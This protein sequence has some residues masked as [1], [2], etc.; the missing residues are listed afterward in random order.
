MS[1]RSRCSTPRTLS[2][3]IDNEWHYLRQS[4]QFSHLPFL[5]RY[6]LFSFHPWQKALISRKTTLSLKTEMKIRKHHEWLKTY[7]ARTKKLLSKQQTMQ[8]TVI[9]NELLN[10]HPTNIVFFYV[11]SLLGIFL[12]HLY[13]FYSN[14]FNRAIFA[15]STQI[16]IFI[17]KC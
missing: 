4:Y 14:N 10:R 15:L 13:E 12:S 17:S 11:E 5:S 16:E 7:L 8:N 6:R 2:I 9:S 1:F 3:P